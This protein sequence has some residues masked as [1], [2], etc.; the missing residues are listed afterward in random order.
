M[1]SPPTVTPPGWYPDPGGV[2]LRWWDGWAWTEFAVPRNPVGAAG[3][4]AV[5]TPSLE[6]RPSAAQPLDPAARK[7]LVWETRF[8]MVAFLLPA[9][10]AAVILF[11]QHTAGVAEVTRFPVIV[12][13]HPVSNLVLG[14]LDYLPVASTPV[15]YL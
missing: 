8:V 2:G 13:G 7:S 10:M 14:I 3:Q 6:V 12:K 9:V 15:P 5:F 1:G 11:A 4:G